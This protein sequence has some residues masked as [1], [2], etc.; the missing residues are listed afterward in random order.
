[1]D[2]TRVLGA[3]LGGAARPPRR[4]RPAGFSLGGRGGQA[5][6]TRAL[7]GLVG[8]AID[9]MTRGGQGAPPASTR[10]ASTHPAAAK[11]PQRRSARLP[12]WT[13]AAPPV[14][15]YTPPASQPDAGPGAGAAEDAETL[16]LIRTMIAA[17]KADGAID[18]AERQVIAEQL[19][20]AGL[21][22]EDRDFVLADFD[23]PLT[24]EAL[25]DHAGDP[26]LRARLYAGAVVA[27]GDIVA[28]ER[29]WLDRLVAALGLDHQAATIIEERLAQ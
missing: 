16:L 17:V 23:A 25:A 5:Q 29:I 6:L 2:L 15:P 10:P 4:R 22:A 12:D 20:A 11:P 9:A 21:G 18:A 3:L 27:M 24:P 8:V 13:T 7:A 28:A 14:S 26:M 19:D 1:M